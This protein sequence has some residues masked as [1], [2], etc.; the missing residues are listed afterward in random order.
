MKQ[1]FV[2]DKESRKHISLYNTIE[3][4]IQITDLQKQEI[5]E[6]EEK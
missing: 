1:A 3:R 4:R 2:K 6:K 5:K